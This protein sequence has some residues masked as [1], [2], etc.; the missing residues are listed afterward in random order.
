MENQIEL[1]SNVEVLVNCEFQQV[2]KGARG[3]VKRLVHNS[4]EEVIGAEIDCNVK[5]SAFL[6]HEIKLI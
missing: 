2:F 6:I 5:L 1:N 3:I 4:D